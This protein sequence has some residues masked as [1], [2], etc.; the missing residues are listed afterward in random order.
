[1]APRCSPCRWR[2][3]K[4]CLDRGNSRREVF[5]S[6]YETF[7]HSPPSVC[8]DVLDSVAPLDISLLHGHPLPFLLLDSVSLSFLVHLPARAYLTIL[9]SAAHKVE[10]LTDSESA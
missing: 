9:R 3:V 2:G 6:S 5:D 7:R 4:L 10:M 1:M 8:S